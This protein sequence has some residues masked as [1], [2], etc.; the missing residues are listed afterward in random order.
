MFT[1][2]R[3]LNVGEQ[4][5][6]DN[7]PCGPRGRRWQ[8]HESQEDRSQPCASEPRD[9]EKNSIRADR[10]M[11]AFCYQAGEFKATAVARVVGSSEFRV[12]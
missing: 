3:E 2:L 6:R 8:L 4:P 7:L 12:L 5:S 9:D 1:F 11:P 10:D